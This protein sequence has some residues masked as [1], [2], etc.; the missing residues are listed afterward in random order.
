MLILCSKIKLHVLI[1][2][3]RAL[4]KGFVSLVVRQLIS[5][6]EDSSVLALLLMFVS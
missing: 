2:G 1:D 3:G 5:V 4:Q 6:L